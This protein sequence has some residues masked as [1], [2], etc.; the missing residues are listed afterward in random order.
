MNDDCTITVSDQATCDL[1]KTAK[2]YNSNVKIVVK[3]V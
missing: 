2:D 1:I 3:E